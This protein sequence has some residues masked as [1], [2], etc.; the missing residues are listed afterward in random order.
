MLYPA[1]VYYK[2]EK[3][4]Q[5]HY[6]RVYCS[7]MIVTFDGIKV[8]FRKDRYQH[9]F[10]ESSRRAGKKDV[11]S[12]KRAERIDWI[13]A[14]LADPQSERY[15][16]WDN[17]KKRYDHNRRVAIVMGNYVVVIRIIGEKKAEFIT[18]FL[19]D[20][21]GNPR[22]PSTIDQIKRGPKWA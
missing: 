20:T 15:V 12:K 17:K 19:A 22:R 8:R 16:G 10:Y 4:Y 9:D 3:E 21:P 14:A 7:S 1:L 2:D 11:F 18:A 6:K 5:R 13:K